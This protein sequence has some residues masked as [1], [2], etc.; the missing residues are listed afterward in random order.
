MHDVPGFEE[1]IL[2]FCI[3][4]ILQAPLPAKKS[5]APGSK[6]DKKNVLAL[7]KVFQAQDRNNDGKVTT[8][9]LY[10]YMK[11]GCCACS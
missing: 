1:R 5:L 3:V 4:T 11:V 9:E 7:F 8:K 2:S 6:Y 10:E